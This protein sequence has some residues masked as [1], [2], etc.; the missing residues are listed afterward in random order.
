MILVF[1]IETKE[2]DALPHPDPRG[3]C[4]FLHLNMNIFKK[5]GCLC[6][7]ETNSKRNQSPSVS[8]CSKILRLD[9]G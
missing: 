9:F 4:E 7:V 6:F 2:F 1:D 5:D 8:G 3:D